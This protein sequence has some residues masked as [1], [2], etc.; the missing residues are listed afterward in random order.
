MSLFT[1]RLFLNI[2]LNYDRL[3]LKPAVSSRYPLCIAD[4][5]WGVSLSTFELLLYPLEINVSDAL[6][7]LENEGCDALATLGHSSNFVPIIHDRR[8]VLKEIQALMK[9]KTGCSKCRAVLS[10]KLNKPVSYVAN[11]FRCKLN[12]ISMFKLEA[13]ANAA[14]LL[15]SE[16]L[17]AYHEVHRYEFAEK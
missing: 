4:D 5:Y 11:D 7:A 13:Y 6:Y 12:S 17:F 16:V 1:R 14:G 9:E 15:L 2:L 8:L 10:Q 3:K